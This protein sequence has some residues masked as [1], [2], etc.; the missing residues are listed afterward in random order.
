RELEINETK[1][2]FA[3]RIGTSYVESYDRYLQ[4]TGG[5]KLEAQRLA[6]ADR[7]ATIDE[8][9]KSGQ[10]SSNGVS[11]PEIIRI[12]STV[13][14]PD[15]VRALVSAMGGKIS[16]PKAPLS[17]IGKLKADFDAGRISEKDYKA[18]LAKKTTS[19]Q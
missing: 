7:N 9:E 3:M 11:D 2:A 5:N 15:Q 14:D 16:E 17:D 13:R 19:T 18:E 4:Q 1:Q 8:L 6:V 12:R 10:F